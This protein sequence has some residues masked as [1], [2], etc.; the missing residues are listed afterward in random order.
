MKERQTMYPEST[1]RTHVTSR[2]CLNAPSHHG[3]VYN[4]FE[5]IERGVYKLHR[6]EM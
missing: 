2:C 1:I 5:R 4:D 3:T 6:D